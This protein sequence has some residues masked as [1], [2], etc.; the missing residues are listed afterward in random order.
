MT[1]VCKQSRKNIKS[2]IVYRRIYFY[3]INIIV[4]SH[5]KFN[6][7]F[8]GDK[9]VFIVDTQAT[10]A[11]LTVYVFRGHGYVFIERLQ[12]CIFNTT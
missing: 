12:S 4:L 6:D 10:P 7:C 2:D 11:T 8:D 5:I 1:D 3:L 9:F